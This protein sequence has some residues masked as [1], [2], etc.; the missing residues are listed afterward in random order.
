MKFKI[1]RIET[2]KG[3]NYLYL[4]VIFLNDDNKIIHHNDFI[5]QIAPT[6]RVYVGRIGPDGEQL[7]TGKEYFKIYDNDVAAEI[8]A[9]IR[10]YVARATMKRSDNRDQRI[11]TEDTDPLGLRARPDVAALIATEIPI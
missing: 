1:M 3:T 8:L 2:L 4:D 6:H 10:H 7:D 9:N 5:M 11:I